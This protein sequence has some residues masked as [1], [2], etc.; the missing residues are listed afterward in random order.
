MRL[1]LLTLFLAACD[2]PAPVVPEAAPV[3]TPTPPTAELLALPSGPAAITPYLAWRGG[4]LHYLWQE[5]EGAGGKGRI[6][7]MISASQTA[8]PPEVIFALVTA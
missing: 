6:L 3:V 5:P 8:L 4:T 7:N 1:S 2:E